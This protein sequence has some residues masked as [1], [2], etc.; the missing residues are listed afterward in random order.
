MKNLKPFLKIGNFTIFIF[1]F[2]LINYKIKSLTFLFWLFKKKFK[3]NFE[4]LFVNPVKSQIIGSIVEQMITYQT[5]WS[6]IKISMRNLNFF[7]KYYFSNL[8]NVKKKIKKKKSV[9]YINSIA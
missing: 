2:T 1:N 9:G 3:S 8:I 7:K 6:N 5:I 4:N